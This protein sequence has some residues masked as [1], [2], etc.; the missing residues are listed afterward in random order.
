MVSSN[1]WD[2]EVWSLLILLGIL[3]FSMLVANL[4]KKTITILRTSLIP[5]S[6]LGGI[7]LLAFTTVYRLITGNIFFNLPIFG[8]SGITTLEI[9]TYHALGIGFIAVT[10]RPTTMKFN[11][12]RN[13]EIFN[14]G[15]TTVST[16]LIQAIFGLAITILFSFVITDFLPAS[17]LLLPFGYGQGTGQALNYGNIYEVDY[18][19]VGG[20]SFGL[21]IAALGFLSAS[22]GGVIYLNILKKKG[23]INFTDEEITEAINSEEIQN[24]DEVP[25]NGSIDKMTIQVAIVIGVYIISYFIMMGLGS[26]VES[27]KSILF[28]FNFLIGVLIATLVKAVLKYLKKVKIVKKEYINGFLMNRIGNFSFDL[29]IVAGIAAIQLDLI[30]QYWYV[31]LILGIVGTFITFFYVRYV[32]NKLFKCYVYEQFFVMYGMLTGTASTGMILLREIDPDFTTPASDNLVYQN[33]PA[34]I[35][36][37]PMML[38]AAFA[39][40]ST[41]STYLTLLIVFLAF[42]VMNIILF[43]KQIFK[44][45]QKN[46]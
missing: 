23:K 26:L 8:A 42:I 37:F 25:M 44:R 1:F 45:K 38:L 15:V 43:R 29:M 11:K 32:C 7:I 6:V 22:I 10:M 4:L 34:I 36:G 41:K 21:T 20:R 5:T 12:E 46:N 14:T 28:G 17:G 35:F 24:E 13:I 31:L 33:L 30:K 3:L 2:T 40:Q 39:P 9:L 16:Y 18:N 19:F 27:L